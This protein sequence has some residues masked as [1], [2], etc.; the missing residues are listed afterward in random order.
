MHSPRPKMVT[1]A[2]H[3]MASL[4]HVTLVLLW[5]I[6]RVIF[7]GGVTVEKDVVAMFHPYCN[8]GGGGERVLW[9]I[10]R[11]MQSAYGKRF[12]YRVYHGDEA[13]TGEA[14]L[15]KVCLLWH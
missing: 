10:V 11:A 7:R 2:L 3:G 6:L 15:A 5:S 12:R 8:D 9:C 1:H 14:I 4:V 13:I